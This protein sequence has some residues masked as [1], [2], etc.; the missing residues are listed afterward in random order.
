MEI[1]RRNPFQ[2]GPLGLP[3]GG[4]SAVAALASI[5]GDAALLAALNAAIVAGGGLGVVTGTLNASQFG[6]LNT[7][8]VQMLPAPG[9]GKTIIPLTFSMDWTVSVAYAT[10]GGNWQLRWSNGQIYSLAAIGRLGT[11]L[12]FQ[13][14]NS[15]TAGY[16]FLTPGTTPVNAAL[17]LHA[18]ANATGAGSAVANWQLIYRIG[19]QP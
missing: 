3:P 6:P 15:T 11:T 5:P 4:G 17:Q 12:Q 16:T 14:F 8:P 9:A 19:D 2:D 7:S 18:T 13:E 10:A 1:P